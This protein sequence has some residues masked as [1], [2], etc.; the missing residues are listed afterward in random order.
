MTALRS[1]NL[2]VLTRG[3]HGFTGE[4]GHVCLCPH[5]YPRRE[6]RRKFSSFRVP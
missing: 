3:G 6:T 1:R 4:N 2:Y 5:T